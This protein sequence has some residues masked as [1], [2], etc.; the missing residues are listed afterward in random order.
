MTETT[1]TITGQRALLTGLTGQDGYYLAKYLLARGCRVAS[2]VKKDELGLAA[3]IARELGPIEVHPCELGEQAAVDALVDQSDPDIVYHLAAQSSV[4]FSW[5]DP[6]VTAHV[7]AMGTL[8]LLDTL[9]QRHPKAVFVMAGS[10]DCFDHELAGPDGVTP[11]TPFKATNPYAITKIMAHQMT[12]C[13]R[14]EYGL[15]ASVAIFFN[16]TSPRRPEIFVERGIVRQAVKVS[17][18]LA[19]AVE[20]GSLETR[21]DW[22]WAPDLVEAFARMGAMDAPV[23]LVLA[24]GQTLTVGDWVRETFQQLGLDADKHLRVNPDRLHRGDRPH[25]FGNIE[26]TCRRLDWSPATELKAM[27]GF[28]IEADRQ[29]F[30]QSAST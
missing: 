14:Q 3:A 23:D 27:V 7:N 25:T 4:G 15:H 9:R 19:E 1:D 29:A 12:Q 21:R 8:Y 13:Y 17:L 10:C 28:L 26:E 20:V 22:S 11:A 18:G 6:V 5:K 30:R 2:G 16:H 24:S